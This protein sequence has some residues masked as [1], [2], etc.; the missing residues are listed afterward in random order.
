MDQKTLIFTDGACLG[1]PGP[2]GWA[3]IIATVD[4]RVKE[5]G[6]AQPS[7]TNNRMELE[8]VI[9]ALAY[10]GHL[11]DS[12]LGEEVIVHS[13]SS[14]VIQGA[15][16]WIRGWQARGWKTSN[17]EGEVKNIDSWQRMSQ[18][19]DNIKGRVRLS[20][21]QVKG[22]AGIPGNE[23]CDEISTQLAAEAEVEFFEGGRAEY[24]VDLSQ[25]G[26]SSEKVKV[27]YLSYI[28]GKIFRDRTWAE[29]EA[30]VR[31][32]KGAKFKKISRSNE[33]AAALK[34]WGVSES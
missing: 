27:Y 6:G 9:Q 1:N 11:N 28:G 10:V 23:R 5:I 13:D 18:M 7:T 34:A 8:A 29:C 12:Q 25:D 33:E 15:T 3:A 21:K 22:H 30:R 19:L 17:G 31:G 4:G 20:F 24:S 26:A 2:G 16:Q 14:Y 32:T